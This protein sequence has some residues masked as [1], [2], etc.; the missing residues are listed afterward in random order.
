MTA[1]SR[2]DLDKVEGPKSSLPHVEPKISQLLRDVEP[3]F[4]SRPVVYVD[5][6]AHRG[7]IFREI[8][9]SPLRLQAAHL[10]E[11]NPTSFA[12]LEA[13]VQE[14]GAE[15][16]TVCHNVA[17]AAGPQRLRLRD[18]GTMTKVIGAPDDFEEVDARQSFDVEAT[19]LDLIVQALPHAHIS[20]LKVDVEGYEREVFAGATTLLRSQAVDLIYVEAGMDP[21]GTQQ[22]YYR[23]IED[24]LRAYDYRLFRVYEQTHEWVEDSPFLRRV[25]LAFL[26]RTFAAD[27][28]YRMSRKLFAAHAESRTLRKTLAEAEARNDA[29]KRELASL[30]VAHDAHA[31]Q[32]ADLEAKLHEVQ[33]KEAVRSTELNRLEVSY[34]ETL[35]RRDIALANAQQRLEAQASEVE[36]LKAKLAT[37]SKEIA[38]LTSTLEAADKGAEAR[39]VEELKAKLATRSKQIAQLT[40]TLEAANNEVQSLRSHIDAIINS[41]SWRLLGPARSIVTMAR[42]RHR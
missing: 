42:G 1:E 4:Y 7:D 8:F 39:E 37:R 33:R 15:A 13:T 6:G 30:K 2:F 34:V 19:T 27:N 17:L 11:P 38:Q 12:A 31:A 3:F 24:T 32:T 23:E 14:L 41:T 20:I 16:T 29:I 5:V 10:I 35:A 21:A 18:A 36:E 25:N 26:S 40:S 9:A 22:T 28:P